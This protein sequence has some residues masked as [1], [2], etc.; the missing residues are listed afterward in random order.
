MSLCKNYL[1][2]INIGSDLIVHLVEGIDIVKH[3]TRQ[4]NARL[5]HTSTLLR[6]SNMK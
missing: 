2:S 5:S 6:K 4:E 3:S 1:G